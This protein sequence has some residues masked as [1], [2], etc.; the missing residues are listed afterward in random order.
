MIR[1]GASAATIQGLQHEE[2]DGAGELLAVLRDAEVA[3]VHRARRRAQTAAAGVLKGFARSQQGLLTDDA[4]ALDLFGVATRIADDPV[5]RNE[6]RRRITGVGHG[7]RV[8]E[9]EHFIVRI[10][11]VRQIFREH[12]DRELI[13]GHGAM[14]TG[15]PESYRRTACNR[16]RNC[17]AATM[18]G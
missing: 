10:G 16:H 7:D 3:A 6:L 12:L 18:N 4:E 11:L 13:F 2:A 17:G 1:R 8:S 15:E 5:S 9:A 14:V